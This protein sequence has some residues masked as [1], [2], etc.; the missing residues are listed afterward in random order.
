MKDEAGKGLSR[1]WRR[2]LVTVALIVLYAYATQVTQIDLKEP[3]RETRQSNL[4]GMIRDLAR[5]DL[6]KFEGVTRGNSISLRMPCPEDIKGSQVTFEGRSLVLVPNCV[7]TTQDLLKLE[8]TGFQPN[9]RGSIFWYPPGETATTRKLAE[10]RADADGHFNAEFTFPDVRPSEELQRI[11]VV[12]VLERNVSGIS[13]ASRITLEKIVETVLMAL[14]ASTIGT[15][16]AVPISFLAARN[17]MTDVGMPL[18]SLTAALILAPIG[19][20][21]GLQIGRQLVSLSALAAGNLLLG[22]LLLI[23]SIGIIYMLL[24]RLAPDS[25]E[26]APSRAA[27]LAGWSMTI[28]LLIFALANAAQIGVVAGSWLEANLGFM[29]FVGNF[30]FVAFD[31]VRLLMSVVLGFV[32]LLAAASVG[33]RFGQNLVMNRPASLARTLTVATTF[34]GTSMLVII[35]I[36]AMNWICVGGICRQLPQESSQLLAV[37]LLPSAAIGALAAAASWRVPVKRPIPV[38][39]V[40][41]TLIR[42]VLNVLR[43]IEPVIM[44]I[45]FVVWVGLGPFAGILALTLHSVADLGKLFS[46]QVENIDE[47]PLEAVTATGANRFQAI[48]FAVVPQVVPHYVAFTFYRWDINVRMSTIIGFVGGGGIGMVLQR[49]TNLTQYRQ[50]AVMIIAIALV[51]TLLDNVSSRIRSRII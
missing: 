26:A 43:A 24:K 10:F 20:Y 30:I 44:G 19:G 12:E 15:I 8:G 35:V 39:T 2:L 31:L 32:A 11:E 1:R 3:F 9:L 14:M 6:F 38:G 18:L 21:A 25:E 22:S 13:D 23:I 34:L 45:V 28:L 29:G 50:A 41:Y 5:P 17:L 27:S 42:G 4:I 33:S 48:V 7:S 16:L 51:V 46:E 36:A 37:L 47:G 49:H 40:S